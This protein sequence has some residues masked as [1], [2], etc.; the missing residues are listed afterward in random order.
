MGRTDPA[1]SKQPTGTLGWQKQSI[2]S[3]VVELD[4]AVCL[5]TSNRA[6]LST[7]ADASRPR[8]FTTT[9]KGGFG[10]IASLLDDPVWAVS[11]RY[12]LY[13]ACI[14]VKGHKCKP[15]RTWW[16]RVLEEVLAALLR[17][18]MDAMVI[19]LAIEDLELVLSRD[20]NIPG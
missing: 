10:S 11:Q 14:S 9:K 6:T 1:S 4:A 13:I 15:G 2:L 16:A 12:F 7:M 5:A 20:N 8:F 17:S 19:A 18:Q 3:I